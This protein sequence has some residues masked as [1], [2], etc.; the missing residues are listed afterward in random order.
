MKRKKVWKPEK[1][2]SRDIKR[3]LAEGDRKDRR[4]TLL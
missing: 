1:V 4:K 3:K 2:E